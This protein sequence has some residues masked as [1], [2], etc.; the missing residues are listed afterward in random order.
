MNYFHLTA[1]KENVVWGSHGGVSEAWKEDKIDEKIDTLHTADP[2]LILGPKEWDQHDIFSRGHW[3]H[4]P[5]GEW[6]GKN[7]PFLNE[8]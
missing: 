8:N 7:T 6:P 1:E 4:P 2:G 3:A 5:K